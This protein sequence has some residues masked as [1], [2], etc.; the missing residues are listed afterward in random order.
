MSNFKWEEE[1]NMLPRDAKSLLPRVKI[2]YSSIHRTQ[3]MKE[4]KIKN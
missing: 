3:L 1:I 4:L 2:I